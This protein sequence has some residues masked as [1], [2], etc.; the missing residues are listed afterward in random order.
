M[1][2]LRRIWKADANKIH[3]KDDKNINRRTLYK[4]SEFKQFRIPRNY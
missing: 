3:H 4:A 1:N 2:N